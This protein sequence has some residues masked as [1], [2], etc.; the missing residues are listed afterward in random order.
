M[1]TR[2]LVLT[3]LSQL[4]SELASLVRRVD[5]L[6]AQVHSL[7]GFE[8][9][10]PA[11]TSA[12]ASS[13]SV[14]S[15]QDRTEAAKQTGQFFLRALLGQPR[16]DSGRGRV[17]LQNRIYVVIRRFDGSV[18]TDPVEVYSHFSAVKAIVAE[19]GRGNQFGDSIYAGFASAWEAKVAVKEAGFVWPETTK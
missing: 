3:A 17:K 7:D 2:D 14:P 4:R 11:T 5:D 15:D 18:H 9:V 6:E 19:G 1:S 8:V 12:P 10:E 13:G 16:G